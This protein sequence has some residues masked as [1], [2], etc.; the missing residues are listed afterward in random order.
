M[1]FKDYECVTEKLGKV[2][3]LVTKPATRKSLLDVG[4][5]AA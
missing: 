4:R 5:K 3:Q 2:S 1:G